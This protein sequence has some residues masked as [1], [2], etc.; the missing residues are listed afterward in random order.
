VVEYTL[1]VSACKLD[2]ISI[3][4][5]EVMDFTYY[6]GSGPSEPKG[7][8]FV[9]N[10]TCG[11]ECNLNQDYSGTF[12][13]D[14][15]TFD[16]VNCIVTVN[17][18]LPNLHNT[19]TTLVLTGEAPESNSKATQIFTITFIDECKNVALEAPEFAETTTTQDLFEVRQ[20]FFK[21]AEVERD[22]CG[23]FEYTIL[24]VP[25]NAVPND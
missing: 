20:Y 8:N 18:A 25:N 9:F 2:V 21:V 11:V 6:L 5:P 19:D 15:F 12:S 23:T 10:P 14:I 13:A 16:A 1:I 22:D 17:T 24:V 4:Q 7:G 3:E